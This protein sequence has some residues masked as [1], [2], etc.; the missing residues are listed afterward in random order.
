MRP[1][2]CGRRGGLALLIEVKAAMS[3]RRRTMVADKVAPAS[4][5][6]STDFNG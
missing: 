1:C 2:D 4:P 3:A 6:R 5:H